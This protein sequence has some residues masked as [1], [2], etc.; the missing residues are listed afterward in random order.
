MS[1]A[2]PGSPQ[3]PKNS[4]VTAILLTVVNGAL[5]GVSSMYV[6][7]RCVPVTLIAAVAVVILAVLVL[8]SR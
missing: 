2:G 8:L 7:T 6:T 4:P 1:S 3:R 5:A